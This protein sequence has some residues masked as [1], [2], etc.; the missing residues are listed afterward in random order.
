MLPLAQCQP[1]PRPFAQAHRADFAGVE[2]APR[3][4]LV[5]RPVAGLANPDSATTLAELLAKELRRREITASTG[6]GHR[7]S[8]H[9]RGEISA[10]P[11]GAEMVLDIVW[12]V[13]AAD[14]GETGRFRHRDS[15]QA[16]VWRSGDDALL[17][18]LARDGAVVIDRGLRRVERELGRP[19]A[20]AGVTMGPVDGVPGVDGP[21]L[22]AAMRHALSE[23]GAPLLPEP[24]DDGLVLLG[25]VHLTPRGA[26]RRLVEV[27]WHLIHPDGRELGRVSQ[28]NEVP[29]HQ[30][31]GSWR[32][33]AS[34]IA[35][36]G[37]PGVL[38]LL[39]RGSGAAHSK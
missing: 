13:A 3:A 7:R 17:Q 33:L 14:G 2:V 4:G 8:H 34:D 9:L 16:A 20:L 35:R 25:S 36:A 32:G 15:V 5:V 26:D 18:R 19:N 1:A 24:A 39:R 6:P 23:A 27:T 28:A 10:R 12:Q 21:R 11:T 38:R 37:A 31:S 29:T 22:A 30:L